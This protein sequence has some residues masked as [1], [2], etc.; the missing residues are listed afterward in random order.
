M[1]NNS[2]VVV[3]Q[4]QCIWDDSGL[5][6]GG[7]QLAKYKWI[8]VLASRILPVTS[9]VGHWKLEGKFLNYIAITFALKMVDL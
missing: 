4:L 8:S 2:N 5:D 3:G 7:S 1:W 6:L 9:H